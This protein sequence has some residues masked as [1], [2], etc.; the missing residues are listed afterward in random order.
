M[1]KCRVILIIN[2]TCKVSI[3]CQSVTI[4]VEENNI[5]HHLTTRL[6][7][8]LFSHSEQEAFLPCLLLSSEYKKRYLLFNTEFNKVSVSRL[9]C[10]WRSWRERH[11]MKEDENIFSLFVDEKCNW[12]QKEERVGIRLGRRKEE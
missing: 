12:G 7:M 6:T 5:S 11:K 1:S 10:C 8:N 9:V 4:S 2:L 3:H